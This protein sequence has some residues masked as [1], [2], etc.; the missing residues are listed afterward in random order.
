MR[1]HMLHEFDR[2]IKR[3]ATFRAAFYENPS[4][5][6]CGGRCC[7]PCTAIRMGQASMPDES[8]QCGERLTTLRTPFCA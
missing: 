4:M 2:I 7:H 5:R 3:L 8:I 1:M 6:C